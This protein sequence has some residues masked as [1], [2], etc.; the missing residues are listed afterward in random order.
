[1]SLPVLVSVRCRASD[2]LEKANTAY[3]EESQPT[4]GKELGK[5]TMVLRTGPSLPIGSVSVR[6]HYQ[7]GRDRVLV[8]GQLARP[9]D[10]A[11]PL[12]RHDRPPRLLQ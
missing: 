10:R 1:M 11:L 7:G 8:G 2:D 9:R 12:H 5:R 4:Q 3:L 6:N